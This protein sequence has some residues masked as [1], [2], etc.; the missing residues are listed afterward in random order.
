MAISTTCTREKERNRQSGRSRI[1]VCVGTC[2]W[3]RAPLA[4]RAP[5]RA[6]GRAP[7]LAHTAAAADLFGDVLGERQ[8]AGP[9]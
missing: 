6:P 2:V 4:G 8:R 3:Q 5:D 9:C 1:C 7:G